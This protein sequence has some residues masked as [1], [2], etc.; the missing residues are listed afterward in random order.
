ML[1]LLAYSHL[2]ETKHYKTDSKVENEI[3]KLMSG[4]PSE[5]YSFGNKEGHSKGV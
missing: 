2:F 4:E 1:F 3:E 5:S